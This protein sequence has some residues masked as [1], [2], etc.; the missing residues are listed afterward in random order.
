MVES[1]E[2]NCR[3][4]IESLDLLYPYQTLQTEFSKRFV[5]GIILKLW[6][7]FI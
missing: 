7:C 5:D 3:N 2:S 6:S 1:K 4:Y